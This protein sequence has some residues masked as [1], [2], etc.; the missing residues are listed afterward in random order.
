MLD[1][2]YFDWESVFSNKRWHLPHLCQEN[3]VYFITFRLR[4]SIPQAKIEFWHDQ[5]ERWLAANPPPHSPE[6]VEQAKELTI[7]KAERFLDRGFGKCVLRNSRCQDSVEHVLRNR[8]GID[9][10]Q[11]DFVIMPNHV[12][13][14][15]RPVGRPDLGTLIG[16]WRSISAKDI[17]RRLSRQGALWQPEPF[18]HIVRSPD[19][20]AKVRRYIRNNPKNL[21]PASARYGYGTLF[22]EYP[23]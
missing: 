14:L 23:Q 1:L 8:D 6:Q 20:L 12:H 10:A 13:V 22:D 15:F 3:V 5:Y 18:D 2:N 19:T 21:P 17:N 11:G 9:Y 16:P 7:R 4:D